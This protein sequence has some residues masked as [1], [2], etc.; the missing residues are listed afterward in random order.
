MIS[1]FGVIKKRRGR[2]PKK[3]PQDA[4]LLPSVLRRNLQNAHAVSSAAELQTVFR[5]E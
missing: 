5:E 4:P 2:P 1:E 3:R